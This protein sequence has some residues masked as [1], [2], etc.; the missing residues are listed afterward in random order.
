MLH[1]S[2]YLFDLPVSFAVI[3]VLFVTIFKV[4]PDVKI[5]WRDV[6]PGAALTAFLFA[7]GKFAIGFYIGKSISA[8]VYGAAGSLVILVAWVY[9]SGI[10][11]YIG[12]EITRVHCKEFGSQACA[13]AARDAEREDEL[14]AG[15]REGLPAKS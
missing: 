7:I 13:V 2:R 3:G 8:S 11:L 4:L 15:Q 1:Q 6:W 9:Y 14:R 12:A 10:I 5:A